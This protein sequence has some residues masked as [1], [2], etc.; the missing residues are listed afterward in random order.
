MDEFDAADRKVLADIERT[1]WSD[2][3]VFPTKENQGNP[4]NYTVGLTKIN[5]AELITMGMVND[6]AHHL[7]RSVVYLIQHG[8]TFKP[9]VYS[10]DVLEGSFDVAFVEVLD[11]Y[12]K[13]YPMNM[14]SHL[15]MPDPTALQVIW[16]DRNNRFPWHPNFQEEF[17]D[18]QVLLGPWMGDL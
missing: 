1:G 17:K 3:G 2:I 7:L 15:E 10:G 4:F 16:P 18:R 12:S 9:N 8:W 11:M 13:D 5:H 6:Q 14:V